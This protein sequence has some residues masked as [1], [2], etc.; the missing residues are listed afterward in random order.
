M[1]DL[2][3]PEFETL[4]LTAPMNQLIFDSG[5]N[6]ITIN[7]PQPSANR[8]IQ[9]PDVG[10]NSNFVLTEGNQTVNGE[11]TFSSGIFLPVIAPGIPTLLDYYEEF[12]SSGNEWIGPNNL[13]PHASEFILTRIG[14]IVTLQLPGITQAADT[15]VVASASIP[16]P[17]RFRSIEN[18][19][20]TLIVTDNSVD[21]LGRLDID[22]LGN[23]TLSVGAT[24]AGF[25]NTNNWGMSSSSFNW[26][27]GV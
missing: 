20:Y 12:T 22:A 26:N 16:I 6:S 25:T 17:A 21:V 2:I 7:A 5:T 8:I 23:M 15:N 11:K 18:K 13:T 1:I 9:I 3:S 14:N 4:T 10:T 27:Q 24:G 19:T